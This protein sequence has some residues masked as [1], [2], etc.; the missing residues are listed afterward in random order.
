MS[1]SFFLVILKVLLRLYRVLDF[2]SLLYW[3]KLGLKLKIEKN[4]RMFNLILCFI[5][6]CF[7]VKYMVMCINEFL[8]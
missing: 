8:K 6:Y 1:F 2:C 3:I 7:V 4:F 5:V